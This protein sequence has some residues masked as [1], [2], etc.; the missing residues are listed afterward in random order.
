MGVDIRTKLKS[1]N[2]HATLIRG[3][4]D[5]RAV[6]QPQNKIVE[7]ISAGLRKKFDPNGVFNQGIMG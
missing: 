4:R 2:G 3:A 1:I 7:N 5:G 6:F